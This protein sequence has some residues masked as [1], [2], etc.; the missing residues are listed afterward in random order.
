MK[1]VILVCIILFALLSVIYVI[2]QQNNIV[3]DGSSDFIDC[4]YE[5]GVTIY[6]TA[7]CPYC[8][9]LVAEYDNF[10]DFDKIYVD[11]NQDMERCNNEMFTNG[12]PEIQIDGELLQEWGSPEV[13]AEKTGCTI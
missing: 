6:G 10:K 3:A 8:V 12:V 9:Q 7:T 4:L 13:L 5:N 11:C 1:V 2:D